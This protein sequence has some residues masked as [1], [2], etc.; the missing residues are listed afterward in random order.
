MFS[1]IFISLKHHKNINQN[2]KTITVFSDPK[3]RP[4]TSLNFFFFLFIFC[5]TRTEPLAF[6]LST[7]VETQPNRQN[8]AKQKPQSNAVKFGLLQNITLFDSLF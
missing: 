5:K 4:L 7:E 6:F 1:E 2:K 8:A 3:P